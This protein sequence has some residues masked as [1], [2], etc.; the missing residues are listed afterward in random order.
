Q[1]PQPSHETFGETLLGRKKYMYLLASFILSTQRPV[2]ET[3]LGRGRT[4]CG[5]R[6]ILFTCTTGPKIIKSNCTINGG[7]VII[8]WSLWG[9][10]CV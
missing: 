6:K 8:R 2:P 10:S 5:E 1:R 4:L 9:R 3:L 7:G